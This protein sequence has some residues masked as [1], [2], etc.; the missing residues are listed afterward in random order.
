MQNT[1]ILDCVVHLVVLGE[2]Y[3]PL[4]DQSRLGSAST[5]F[6]IVKGTKLPSPVDHHFCIVCRAKIFFPERFWK[7]VS[8]AFGS[9]SFRAYNSGSVGPKAWEDVVQAPIDC[10]SA[11]LAGSFTSRV[12]SI[13]CFDTGSC[14]G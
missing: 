7:Y 2:E 8:G 6:L 13:L 3:I 5:C 1:Q 10:S 12:V 9:F 11:I 4:G 14:P